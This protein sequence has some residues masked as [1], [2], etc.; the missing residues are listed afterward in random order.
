MSW[1]RRRP[2]LDVQR[3]T[4]RPVPSV[5]ESS[6]RVLHVGYG[7][8]HDRAAASRV[9]IVVGG[10]EAHLDPPAMTA[11]WMVSSAPTTG[12]TCRERALS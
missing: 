12:W 6:A 4:V 3:A 10:V 9:A 2:R 8:I 7:L 11:A 1:Q 5:S